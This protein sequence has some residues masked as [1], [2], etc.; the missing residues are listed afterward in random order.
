MTITLDQLADALQI[1][2][3]R[4]AGES[5]PKAELSQPGRGVSRVS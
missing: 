5:L 3:R 4:L 2:F 1:L